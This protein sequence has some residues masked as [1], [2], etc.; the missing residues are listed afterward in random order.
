MAH[1]KCCKMEIPSGARRC[2]FCHEANPVDLTDGL[3]LLF[4][5][6]I[7]LIVAFWKY[8]L[9]GL[10]IALVAFVVYSMYK[11]KDE[12]SQEGEQ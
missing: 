3:A 12:Q 6:A 10:G 11:D 7:G 2:P 1:C 8:I 4:L 5:I 9:W